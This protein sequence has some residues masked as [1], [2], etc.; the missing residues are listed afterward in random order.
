MIKEVRVE[1]TG[2]PQQRTRSGSFGS[3]LRRFFSSSKT[4]PTRRAGSLNRPAPA[5]PAEVSR[6]S[7]VP[8]AGATT[9][10]PYGLHPASTGPQPHEAGYQRPRQG[11][12]VPPM[13][14]VSSVQ[15][16]AR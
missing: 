3:N 2:D 14:D 8:V 10:S 1:E 12:P 5:A 7:S 9:L 4:T 13:R 6:E 15:Y 11:T 16:S